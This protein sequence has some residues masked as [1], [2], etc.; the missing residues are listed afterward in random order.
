MVN[1]FRV[2]RERGDE[3]AA[4]IEMTPWAREEYISSYAPTDDSLER[5]RRLIVRVWQGH[6]SDGLNKPAGWRNHG[7]HGKSSTVAGWIKVPARLKPAIERL[8][9]TEIEQCPALDLIKRCN[10]PS[11][12][13]YVDPPYVHSTRV[14]RS[15]YQYEM[16]DA[17]DDDR[18]SELWQEVAKFWVA[19]GGDPKAAT[20]I[21][22]WYNHR[23]LL[24]ALD[25]HP[26]PVVLSGYHCALYDDRL[27]HWQTVEKRVQAEK[28]NIRTEVLWLNHAA[29]PL[30]AR[31]F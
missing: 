6:N 20:H 11:A 14:E 31:M 30:Q 8:K 21:A 24:D 28:G 26:G 27:Q 22:N 23:L 15:F 13:L 2:I 5:A 4:Q 3:L 25:A 7:F 16:T 1:L 19:A 10:T 18:A 29:Q 9:N 17:T 12:L